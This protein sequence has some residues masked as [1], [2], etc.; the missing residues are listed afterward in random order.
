MIKKGHVKVMKRLN[1]IDN[2]DMFRLEE[3]DIVP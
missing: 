2:T 3:D 1:Y